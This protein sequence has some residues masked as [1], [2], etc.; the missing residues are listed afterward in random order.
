MLA[1]SGCMLKYC[2]YA[3]L[4][5]YF[6]KDDGVMSDLSSLRV[7]QARRMLAKSRYRQLH[8]PMAFTARMFPAVG[9]PAMIV[10]VV[11]G[12]Y[13]L[14]FYG[15]GIVALTVVGQVVAAPFRQR[16]YLEMIAAERSVDEHIGM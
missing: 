1:Q 10:G 15:A 2:C 16:R 6:W 3:G 11:F 5:D 12:E 14:A 8:E 7:L 13:W 4:P 9:V